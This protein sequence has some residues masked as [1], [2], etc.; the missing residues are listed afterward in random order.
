VVDLKLCEAN[1]RCAAAGSEVFEMRND[2][3]HVRIENP[4]TAL[5]E[6]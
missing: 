4:P 6:K 3:A 2:Q 5:W 1:G